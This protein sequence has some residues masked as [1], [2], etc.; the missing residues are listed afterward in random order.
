MYHYWNPQ[1]QTPR[2]NKMSETLTQKYKNPSTKSNV[3]SGSELFAVKSNTCH[4]GK[5]TTAPKILGSSANISSRKG[6]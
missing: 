6:Q 1:H 2:Y 4:D 5:D 3:S